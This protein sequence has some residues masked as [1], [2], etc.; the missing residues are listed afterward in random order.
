MPEVEINEL[1]LLLLLLF[2]SSSLSSVS[3]SYSLLLTVL[4]K[5]RESN[6]S[7][8]GRLELLSA[9]EPFA[10]RLFNCKTVFLPQ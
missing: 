3:S 2:L 1:L 9:L 7:W 10:V 6:P 8:V 5:L 4:W